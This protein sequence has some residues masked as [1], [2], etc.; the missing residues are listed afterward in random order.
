VFSLCPAIQALLHEFLLGDNFHLLVASAAFYAPV[1]NVFV[2]L[3]GFRPCDRATFKGLLRQGRSVG[4]IPGG[5]A[6]MFEAGRGRSEEVMRV[7]QRKGFVRLA[8]ETGAQIVP[9]YCFG[10]S[11][12]FDTPAAG[13]GAPSLL[14]RCSRALRTSLVVF[15]GRWGLPVPHRV[16]LLTVI[17]TPIPCPQVDEP[18]PEL[19]N[20][21]H[22]L[23]LRETR[24][25]YEKYRNAYGWKDKPLVF[26]R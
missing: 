8:L 1:Y 12:V 14:A 24:R 9:C 6:E 11:Q 10:N 19:V 2:R 7:R 20:E 3:A 21:Y 4:V 16:P 25:I 23:Y 22:D 17:G 13:G 5:I 18:S 15:W 26:K